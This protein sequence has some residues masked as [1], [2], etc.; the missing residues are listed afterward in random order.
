M[1]IPQDPRGYDA[2]V[3]RAREGLGVQRS[4]AVLPAHQVVVE[5]GKSGT[6]QEP[7]RIT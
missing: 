2:Q 1:F 5:G 4:R 7:F 6:Y 3:W